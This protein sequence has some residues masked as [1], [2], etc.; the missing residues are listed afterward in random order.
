MGFFDKMPKKL[1][2]SDAQSNFSGFT[3]NRLEVTKFFQYIFL[4]Q[5]EYRY[6]L[7]NLEVQ[8]LNSFHT[9]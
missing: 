5:I 8:L 7:I 9:A 4:H 6:V 3:V 2:N 1:F